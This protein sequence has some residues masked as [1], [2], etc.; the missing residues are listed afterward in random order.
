MG[1]RT[2]ADLDLEVSSGLSIPAGE[3]RQAAS[4]SSG[5]GGQ[6]VNKSATRVS[7]RWNI[8]SSDGTPPRTTPATEATTNAI[9]S[10]PSHAR[11][12]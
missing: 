9:T 4:R 8:R 3:L 10:G 6:H 2:V 12:K 11:S 1:S 7:L 5:P